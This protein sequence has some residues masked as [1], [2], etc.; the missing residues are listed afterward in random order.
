MRIY[1]LLFGALSIVS[2]ILAF[3]LEDRLYKISAIFAGFLILIVTYLGSNMKNIRE[4]SE[5]SFNEIKK[6]NEKVNIY[7]KIADHD[8]RLRN[9]ERGGING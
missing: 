5:S 3:N 7:E 9:L 8:T 4:M 1:E 6:L 2:F